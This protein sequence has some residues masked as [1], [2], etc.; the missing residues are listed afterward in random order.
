MKKYIFIFFFI[1]Y[2][3]FSQISLPTFHGIQ[4]TIT[5]ENLDP[6]APAF[7]S[8]QELNNFQSGDPLIIAGGGGGISYNSGN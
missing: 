7:C 3:L 2:N 1:S 8:H 4:K 6:C 5:V